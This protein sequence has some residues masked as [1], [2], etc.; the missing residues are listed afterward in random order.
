MINRNRAWYGF[1]LEAKVEGD[2]EREKKPCKTCV[3]RTGKEC[4]HKDKY[5]RYTGGY[6]VVP[7]DPET[8]SYVHDE[9]DYIQKFHPLSICREHN[10]WFN[11][12]GRECTEEGIYYEYKKRVYQSWWNRFEGLR[13]K[14]K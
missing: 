9:E 6:V 12:R 5:G 8:D 1:S 13:D 7:I 11:G 10:R 4:H 2:A 14:T 3:Y